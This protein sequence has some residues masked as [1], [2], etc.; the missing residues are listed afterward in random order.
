MSEINI[1]PQENE[2][3]EINNSRRSKKSLIIIGIIAIVAIALIWFFIDKKQ[4]NDRIAY[5]DELEQY[6]NTMNDVRMEIIDAAALGEEMMNEYA[7]VW[8]TTIYDDMVEVDGQYYFDFSEAIWAQQ[9]VF[10]EEGTMGEMEAYIESV[11]TM[12]DDLNNPPAEFKDEYDLFLETY[13]V[14]NE[15]A[16]LAISPEGSLTSLTKK[17]IL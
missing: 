8:S 13:L 7:Y 17:E 2:A 15:F 6:H 1:S 10:E 3:V 12:M 4:E 9:A 11:D 14:F 5:L 16:D